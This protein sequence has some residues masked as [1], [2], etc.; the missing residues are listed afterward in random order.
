MAYSYKIFRIKFFK[1]ENLFNIFWFKKI[2]Q[3]TF[4]T[5]LES[6]NIFLDVNWLEFK[7]LSNIEI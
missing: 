4:Q 3:P 6:F 5:E 2:L 7:L 1:C